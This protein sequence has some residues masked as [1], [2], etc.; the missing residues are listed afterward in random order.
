MDLVLQ[1]LAE[2]G[3]L[4]RQ[5]RRR[6]RAGPRRDPSRSPQGRDQGPHHRR[7]ARATARLHAR[8]LAGARAVARSRDPR[9]RVRGHG[10]RR[11]AG[12]RP[13]PA[14]RR[15]RL[16]PGSRG[17]PSLPSARPCTVAHDRGRVGTAVAPDGL[18]WLPSGTAGRRRPPPETENGLVRRVELRGLEPL[19]PTLPVWCA[20]SCATAPCRPGLVCPSRR[21]LYRAEQAE[22]AQ[23]WRRPRRGAA[24][25]RASSALVHLRDAQVVA[26]RVPQPEVDAVAAGRPAPR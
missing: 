12:A 26:E 21:Q 17:V 15:C 2:R 23:G 25:G 16:T 24:T 9:P 22:P 19:T 4:A 11:H 3:V 6:R 5:R 14:Q 10:R 1:A 7:R 18:Q 13:P 8:R 20:T